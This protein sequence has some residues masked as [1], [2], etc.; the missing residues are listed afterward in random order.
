[1]SLGVL[2]QRTRGRS[3]LRLRGRDVAHRG[4]S[5]IFLGLA[6]VINDEVFA[7]LG[8]YIFRFL[9]V[10]SLWSAGSCCEVG[11]RRS[12]LPSARRPSM[13]C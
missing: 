10:C 7:K 12:G 2:E 9:G 8:G 13:V 6:G 5:A 3:A 11:H 4:I 1:M